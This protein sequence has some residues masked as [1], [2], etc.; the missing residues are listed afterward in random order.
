MT[1]RFEV[2]AAVVVCVGLIVGCGSD[3]KSTDTTASAATTTTLSTPLE[4]EVVNDVRYHEDIVGL[5]PPL[6]DVYAP[7]NGADWPTVVMFHGGGGQAADKTMMADLARTVAAEGAVVFAPTI[8]GASEDSMSRDPK[9][10]SPGQAECA[11]VFA[12]EHAAEYGGDPQKLTLFGT[13]GGANA[14]GSTLWGG[15]EPQPGCLADGTA[16]EPASAVLF[17]G[18]WLLAPWWDDALAAGTLDYQTS[19]VWTNLDRDLNTDVTLVVGSDSPKSPNHRLPVGDP[20]ASDD[21]GRAVEPGEAIVVAGGMCRYFELRDPDGDLRRDLQDLGVLAD[22]FLDIS[23]FTLLL[24]DQLDD[25]GQPAE[26]IAVEG[27]SHRAEDWAKA[28]EL[29][30]PIIVKATR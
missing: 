17:E 2:L 8:G 14:A 22:G 6:L 16:P 12:V 9:V 26:L 19:T 30:T 1:V 21:C 15:S 29:L 5:R 4:I 28:P 18:D 10:F 23:D 27:F 3:E 11:A 25:A 7:I 13:S 24:Q 20:F